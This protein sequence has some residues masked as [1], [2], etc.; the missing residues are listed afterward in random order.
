[1]GECGGGTEVVM[2][3][4]VGSVSEGRK[5]VELWLKRLRSQNDYPPASQQTL[6]RR[7][8]LQNITPPAPHLECPDHHREKLIAFFFLKNHH[9][10]F[11]SFEI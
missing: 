8:K 9:I 1:M 2:W 11:F 3:W 7:S 4:M 5:K 6:G 10:Q